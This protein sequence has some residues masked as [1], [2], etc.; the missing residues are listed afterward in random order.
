LLYEPFLFFTILVGIA[1]L[2]RRQPEEEV[3]PWAILLWGVATILVAVLRSGEAISLGAGVLPLALFGG[4]TVREFAT[5]LSVEDRRGGGLHALAAFVFWLPGVLAMVQH[6][7]GVSYEDQMMLVVAG[8]IVLLALQALLA[9]LFAL[10]VRRDVLWRSALVG[11]AAVVLIFQAS[12]ALGLGFVR[13]DSPVEP[14]LASATSEDLRHLRDILLDIGVRQG[15][16]R[17]ALRVAIIEEDAELVR[18]LRWV[19]R[20]FQRLETV[21]LWPDDPGVLVLTPEDVT[22]DPPPPVEGLRGIG[23][24]AT[25]TYNAPVPACQELVPPA[26]A[27]FL[28]WYFYRTSPYEVGRKSVILWQAEAP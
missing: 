3:Y 17:D 5:G 21:D 6:A 10:M 12:F 25:T 22:L 8:L 28:R 27:D 23:F 24:V 14:A 11:L 1:L 18:S 26:C 9:F 7:R 20:D 2:M 16:R 19:L 4:V 15:E 13:A